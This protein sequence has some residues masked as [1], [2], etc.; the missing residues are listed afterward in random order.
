MPMRSSLLRVGRPR[1]AALRRATSSPSSA[2]R[3]RMGP[4]ASSRA[5]RVPRSRT[6]SGS[7]RTR[8]ILRP[9]LLEL[10]FAVRIAGTGVSVRKRDYKF[11]DLTIPETMSDKDMDRFVRKYITSGYHHALSCRIGAEPHGK[12]PS[13]VNVSMRG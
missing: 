2:R 5:S 4:S 8:W 12:R 1:P 13:A 10:C 7:S 11:V 3:S 9:C 6:T